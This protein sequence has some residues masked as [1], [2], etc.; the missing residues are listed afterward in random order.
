MSPTSKYATLTGVRAVND[1]SATNVAQTVINGVNRKTAEG[2]IFMPAFGDGYSDADIAAVSNYRHR[3]LRRR[4][5]AS[6]RKR[7]ASLRKQAAQQ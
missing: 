1:P 3:A 5:R 6:H 7:L 4:G 2:M